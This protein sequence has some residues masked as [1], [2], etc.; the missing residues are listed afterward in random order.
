MANGANPS[1][2]TKVLDVAA[3]NAAARRGAPAPAANPAPGQPA[4]TGGRGQRGGTG[5]GNMDEERPPL[6]DFMGGMTPLL[7]ASRQGHLDASQALLD[8]GASVNEVSTGDKTSPLLIATVN[9]QYDLAR[10]LLDKG[11]DPRLAS[12]AGATPLYTTINVKWAPKSDYPQPDTR[13]QRTSHLELMTA[14]LDRGAD[15]NAKLKNELWYSSYNFDLSQVNAGGATAFW[16]AAQASDVEAMRLLVSRG[17]DPLIK[18][19]DAVSPLHVASGA[20]VHGNDEVTATGSWMPGVKFL[21]DEIHA[22]VNEADAKGYTALH[23]AAARGDNEM[24]LFLVARGADPTKVS[25][26]GQTVADMA[27]GPRQRIQPFQDTITLLTSLGSR[28][29]H[30]CVSC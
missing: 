3:K 27:N 13:Q 21:V 4:A 17:A 12:T 11:A 10:F 18:A 24:I 5:G 25:K 26:S 1:I 6:I 30:K 19:N 23:N 22:D 16:R 15:P 14:L 9:G 28:N 7:L 8:G 29:S 2:A 20:G